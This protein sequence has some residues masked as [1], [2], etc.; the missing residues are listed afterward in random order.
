MGVCGSDGEGTGG[1]GVKAA[2]L[3]FTADDKTNREEL[4]KC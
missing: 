3:L 2:R 4:N 1:G